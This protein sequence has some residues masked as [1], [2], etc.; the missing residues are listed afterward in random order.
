[1]TRNV[2]I[3]ATPD[4]SYAARTRSRAYAASTPSQAYAYGF[5]RSPTLQEDYRYGHEEAGYFY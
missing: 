5:R 3:A 4:A 2:S 1:M